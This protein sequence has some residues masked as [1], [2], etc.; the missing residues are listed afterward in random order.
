VPSKNSPAI[1]V[2]IAPATICS[3]PPSAEAMPA[4]RL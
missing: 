3:V 2:I 4:M 1:P